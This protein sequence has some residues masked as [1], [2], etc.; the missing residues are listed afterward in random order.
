MF[1]CLP[2]HVLLPKGRAAMLPSQVFVYFSM[3]GRKQE[4][5]NIGAPMLVCVDDDL[6]LSIAVSHNR[7]RTASSWRWLSSC[8]RCLLPL[9][10]SDGR[11]DGASLPL[12]VPTACLQEMP[13]SADGAMPLPSLSD[14]AKM[15]RKKDRVKQTEEVKYC[16]SIWK[17]L[18]TWL[19]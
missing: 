11:A 16:F 10:P 1:T 7:S 9:V 18:D 12:A 5:L 17:R 14:L 6:E 8:A 3:S 19:K 15:S 13:M 4:I 2:C